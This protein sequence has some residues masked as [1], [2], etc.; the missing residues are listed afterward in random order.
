MIERNIKNFDVLKKIYDGEIMY[1]D[2]KPVNKRL[3]M[4]LNEVGVL[5]EQNNN[6]V[7]EELVDKYTEIISLTEVEAFAKGVA[8]MDQ[9]NADI[10]KVCL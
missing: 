7:V 4:L 10:K 8:F 2:K 3:E 6:K 1:C 9:L 5:W